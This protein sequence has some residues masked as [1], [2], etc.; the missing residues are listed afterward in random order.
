MAFISGTETDLQER[1][2]RE[3]SELK[4]LREYFR[5]DLHEYARDP[6]G[7]IEETFDVNPS[8]VEFVPA[9]QRY[10]LPTAG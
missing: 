8:E 10:S 6:G 7:N 4:F 5:P 9:L 3:R 1:H 2:L